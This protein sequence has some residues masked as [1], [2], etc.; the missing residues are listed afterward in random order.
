LQKTNIWAILSGVCFV[1]EGAMPGV[2]THDTIAVVSGLVMTPLSYAALMYRGEAP[3]QAATGTLIVVGAHLIGSW[4]L[5][6]DLDIDSAIDDR[7]GPFFWI[8]RPYMW[9]VP[10]RHRILSHSGFSALLRLLYL[11][12]ILA[13]LLFGVTALV[14]ALGGAP[15][16]SY[17]RAFNDWVLG[18]LVAYP[19]EATLAAIGVVVSDLVHTIADLLVTRGKRLLRALGIRIKKDYRNHDRARR[20]R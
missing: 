19:R 4:W 9:M 12:I 13:G 8:W 16:Y 15:E 2:K 20:W 10:H 18:L 6:P 17:T 14:T 11:Y 5:S 1:N 7:W 3:E